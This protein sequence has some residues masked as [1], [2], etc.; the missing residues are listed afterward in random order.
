MAMTS[1]RTNWL[2]YLPAWALAHRLALRWP[3]FVAPVMGISAGIV[4]LTMLS[5]LPCIP[6]CVQGEMP[7][8]SASPWFLCDRFSQVD[9]GLPSALPLPHHHHAPPRGAFEP[10]LVQVGLIPLFVLLIGRLF[11]SANPMA[12]RLTSAPPTP[13]PRAA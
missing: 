1:A 8:A 13:P 9:S 10:I 7:A 4:V 12:L 11:V 5:L 2:S 6:H 3:S